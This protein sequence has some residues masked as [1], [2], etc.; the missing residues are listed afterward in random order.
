MKYLAALEPLVVP[1]LSGWDG[2]VVVPLE[3][4]LPPECEPPELPE[5]FADVFT[6]STVR[7]LRPTALSALI[8]T[9]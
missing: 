1:L 5:D 3:D 9:V 8:F 2:L 4:E 6:S 7:S